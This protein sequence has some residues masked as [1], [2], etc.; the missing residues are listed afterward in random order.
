[1][2]ALADFGKHAAEQKPYSRSGYSIA[3]PSSR[4]SA[5]SPIMSQIGS[6]IFPLVTFLFPLFVRELE[7][8]A[9]LVENLVLATTFESRGHAA[10]EVSAEELR[11]E[12]LE[13]PLDGVGLLQHVDAVRIFVH[14][15]LDRLDVSFN[16]RE[17]GGQ[18]LLLFHMR[19][20]YPSPGGRVCALCYRPA[21]QEGQ[22]PARSDPDAPH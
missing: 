3:S 13:R 18:R 20:S 16:A 1:F 7:Y 10:G 9:E 22:R 11:L 14:H 15:P 8:V 4:A 2:G 5:R 12:A 19:R 21:P 17:S 6:R